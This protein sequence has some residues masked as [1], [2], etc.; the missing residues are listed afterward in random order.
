MAVAAVELAAARDRPG[1]YRRILR[2]GPIVPVAIMAGM[3]A[4]AAGAEVLAPHPP[5]EIRMD[6]ALKPP[7]FVDGGAPGYVLGTDPLG[8]DN[9]SRLMYGARA[10][11]LVACLSIGFSTVIGTVLGVVAGYAGGVTDA[12]I[13]RAVDVVLTFPVILLA[14]IF[15]VTLGPSLW[16]VTAIL[17]LVLWSRF[18][19]LVRGEVLSWKEREFVTYARAAGAS[20]ARIVVVHLLPNVAN[21]H[22][23]A[24]DPPGRVRDRRRGIAELS[25]SRHPAPCAKLGRDDRGRPRLPR[26]RLVAGHVSGG[27]GGA[28]RAELQS[29]R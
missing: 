24:C 12:V 21:R 18:A 1:A 6:L 9:L 16:G 3:I 17:A 22:R 10:S 19:R 28:D 5:L 4:M 27:R 13:M 14:L 23:R 8:R 29:V 7:S 25:G 20:P 11:L 26:D 2:R 15:V